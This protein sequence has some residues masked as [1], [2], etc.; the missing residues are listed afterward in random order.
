MKLVLAV[1]TEKNEFEVKFII[2]K[3]VTPEVKPKIAS[4]LPIDMVVYTS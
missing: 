1:T 4:R 2:Y 3:N